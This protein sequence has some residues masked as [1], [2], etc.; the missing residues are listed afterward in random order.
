[1]PIKMKFIYSL[2]L[3]NFV[4]FIGAKPTQSPLD[5]NYSDYYEDN[6]VFDKTK[7][8]FPS[9]TDLNVLPECQKD[10][11]L[12]MTDTLTSALKVGNHY[13]RFHTVCQ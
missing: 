9:L 2:I 5:E 11:T 6:A 3:T 10:C 8:L 7:P 4:I 13:D 12:H 1:M